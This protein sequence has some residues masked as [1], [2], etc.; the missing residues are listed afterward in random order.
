MLLSKAR[1][2]PLA[3]MAIIRKP[4][5]SLKNS[6]AINR[7]LIGNNSVINKAIILDHPTDGPDICGIWAHPSCRPVPFSG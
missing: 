5:H 7:Y 6:P 4:S 3:I 2:P 1:Y